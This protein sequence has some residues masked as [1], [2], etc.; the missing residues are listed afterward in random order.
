MNTW[1]LRFGSILIA[2]ALL[3]G[4]SSDDKTDQETTENQ[5]SEAETA[6]GAD[7]ENE[8]EEIAHFTLSID[9]GDEVITE[10]EVSIAEGDLL[11]DVLKA[12]FD[13]EEEGGFITSIEG[14]SPDEGEEKSWMFFVN[15][16]M[17]T[18]GAEEVEL[19]P[20]D[21]VNFDLQAWE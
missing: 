9:E 2:A 5:A 10:K 7:Q 20:G 19:N 11:M 16:E 1:L 17:A 4:C 12:N 18:T 6:T 15:D 14:V 3:T 13:V 21:Q 8:E